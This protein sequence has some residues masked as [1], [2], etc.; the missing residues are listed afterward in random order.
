MQG[1]SGATAGSGPGVASAT[2][3]NNK[4]PRRKSLQRH[5]ISKWQNNA[6]PAAAIVIA[7]AKKSMTA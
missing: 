1:A 7:T 5:E 2:H 3:P 4:R 6:N